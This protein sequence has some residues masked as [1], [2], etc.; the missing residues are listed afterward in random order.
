[1][2]NF[3]VAEKNISVTNIANGATRLQPVVLGI[4]QA[5]GVLAALSVS[6]QK[7]PDEIGVRAVQKLY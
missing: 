7:S 3:I 1:M 2:S 4:G 5:A 6:Q